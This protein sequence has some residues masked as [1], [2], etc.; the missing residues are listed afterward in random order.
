MAD[1]RIRSHAIKW[2]PYHLINFYPTI[3]V[4]YEYQWH[5]QFSLQADVGYVVKYQ[6]VK[7]PFRN[8]RFID[9]RGIKLK[10]EFRYYLNEHTGGDNSYLSVEPYQNIINFDRRV[11][12]TECFDLECTILYS[13]Q[14]LYKVRYRETGISIKY[15]L[16]ERVGRFFL[17]INFGLCLRNVNYK[18]PGFDQQR[19]FPIPN[20]EKR[21]VIGPVV[22]IRLGYRFPVKE[23]PPIQR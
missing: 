8:D 9:K 21:L 16:I 10:T 22:G 23:K 1:K 20:E 14:Y 7:Y 11:T 6:F 4:A 15:G 12:R 18:K 19:W 5:P 2:S 13:K 3:Q 17:D